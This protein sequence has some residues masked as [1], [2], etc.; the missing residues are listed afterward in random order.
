MTSRQARILGCL[1]ARAVKRGLRRAEDSR[2]FLPVTFLDGH[3][4]E[5]V[6]SRDSAEGERPGGSASSV[7][8][9]PASQERLLPALPE[10]GPPPPSTAF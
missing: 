5:A 7:Q 4:L 6:V 9:S 8:C 10:T 3:C 2:A 1:G